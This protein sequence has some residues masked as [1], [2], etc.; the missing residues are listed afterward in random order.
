MTDM[1]DIIP[2]RYF[3]LDKSMFYARDLYLA[4]ISRLTSSC[5]WLI[6]PR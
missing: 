4:K 2:R 6:S 5:R 1:M 3:V